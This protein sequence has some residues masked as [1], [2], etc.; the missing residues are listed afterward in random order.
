MEVRDI[1]EHEDGSATYQFDMNAQE[2]DAMCR[3]GILW[4]IVC[5][6]T[7]LTVDKVIAEYLSTE[8]PEETQEDG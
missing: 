6:A 1:I 4:A 5:G 3:N 8:A 2:H 7:G